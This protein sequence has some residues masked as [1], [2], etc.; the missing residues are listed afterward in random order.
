[1]LDWEEHA[2]IAGRWVEGACEG[3]DQERPEAI[4]Q[5]E[6][7]SSGDHDGAGAD[8]E[9]GAFP[10]ASEVPDEE[11]EG[12]GAEQGGGGEDADPDGRVTEGGEIDREQDADK[13]SAKARMPREPRMIAASLLVPLGRNVK[14]R[15][16]VGTVAGG[17]GRERFLLDW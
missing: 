8:E 4:E 1:L 11:G 5:G 13:P 17:M 14:R 6:A 7:D 3:D 2:D 15:L 12:G 10:A 16:F 9:V